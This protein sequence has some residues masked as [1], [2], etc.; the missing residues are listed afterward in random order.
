[1]ISTAR[2]KT[3]IRAVTNVAKM[4]RGNILSKKVDVKKKK[5][6]KQTFSL[7][8]HKPHRLKQMTLHPQ[9]CCSIYHKIAHSFTVIPRHNGH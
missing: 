8:I 6:Q 9:I 4:I 5:K 2:T 3:A 1:M 7:G